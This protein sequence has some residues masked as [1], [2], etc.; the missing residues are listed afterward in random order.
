LRARAV[1]ISDFNEFDY[2]VAMDRD[3]LRLLE[4]I[5]PPESRA[6]LRLMLSYATLDHIDEVPDPY[7]GGRQGFEDVLDMLEDAGRGLLQNLRSV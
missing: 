4:R 7:Y 5:R 6:E 2:I 3:N 1:E